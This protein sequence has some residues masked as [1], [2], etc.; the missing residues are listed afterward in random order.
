MDGRPVEN[1]HIE[2]VTEFR[3]LTSIALP[4][5]ERASSQ[6]RASPRF[7]SELYND[8]CPWVNSATLATRKFTAENISHRSY[9]SSTNPDSLR[10]IPQRRE[11]FEEV[12]KNRTPNLDR[13][14][15][16]CSPTEVNQ[17]ELDAFVDVDS[18]SNRVRRFKA[19]QLEPERERDALLFENPRQRV[20]LQDEILVDITVLVIVAPYGKGREIDFSA[21]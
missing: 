19:E 9:L 13:P 1:S 8:Q 3:T 7:S 11:I 2:L 17:F 6:E 21:Q 12:W 20:C 16:R 15:W 10:N 5:A 18:A 14:T 4:R